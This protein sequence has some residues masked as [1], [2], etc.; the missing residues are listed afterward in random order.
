MALWERLLC[1]GL[2]VVILVASIFAKDEER[3]EEFA[4]D[5]ELAE[6]T[7][8]RY[9]RILRAIYIIVA[10]AVTMTGC[11]C[12]EWKIASCVLTGVVVLLN[13]GRFIANK[14]FYGVFT[15]R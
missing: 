15:T 4:K 10:I 14:I 11:L 5:K 2:G 7:N 1:V 6:R 12:K 9:L 8:R 3:V 13:V